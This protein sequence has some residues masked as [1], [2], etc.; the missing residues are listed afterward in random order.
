VTKSTERKA[1]KQETRSA[2]IMNQTDDDNGG[3]DSN[4]RRNQSLKMDRERRR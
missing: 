1:E 2:R 4:G 3:R